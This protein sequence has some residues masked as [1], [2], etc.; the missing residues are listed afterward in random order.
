MHY[1]CAR[2]WLLAAAMAAVLAPAGALA[3]PQSSGRVTL[4]ILPTAPTS[5]HNRH[6]R[7]NRAPLAPSPLVKLPV[8]AVK[9]RGWVLRQLQLEADGMV[10]RLAEISPWLRLEG[11]AWASPTGE[12]A[13]GWEEL[14]YW[15]RGFVDLG[16]VLGDASI[17]KEGRRWVD[18]ILASQRP[19]GYFGP[20]SNRAWPDLWPNMLALY[21]LRSHHE[22]TRDP[23]VIPFMLRYFQWQTSL[24]FERLLADSWQ[25]WRGGD[26]LDILHW[27]YNETGQKWLL[28]QARVNHERTA[29][30]TGG[31]PTWH[32]VNVAQ[33]FREPAQFWQQARDPRYLSATYR[34][35]DTVR[36]QYGEAPGGLFGADEVARPGYTGPRQGAETCTMVE[37][38][39]SHEILTAITGDPLWADRCEEVAFNS[40]P[41]AMTADLRGLHY[42]TAP[43]QVQLDRASKAPMI[44]NGGDMFSYSPFEQYRCC[45]HNVAFGWPYYAEYQWMATPGDGLAAVLYG[46]C[47]VTARVA[48]GTPVTIREETEYP[49]DDTIVFTVQPGAPARFPLTLRI[50]AWCDSPRLEVNGEGYALTRSRDAA[51]DARAALFTPDRG[52]GGWVVVKRAW[53]P[54]DIVRL[55]LPMRV[56]VKEWARNRGAVSVHRGPLTYALRI[57]ERWAP[58]GAN[59]RWPG[60]EV[61]ATMPWNYG[62]EVDPGSAEP[63]VQVV[64]KPAALAAQPFTLAD[65]PIELRVAA[66]R[67]TDWTLE[68]NGLVGEVQPGPV[69]SAEPVE[70][71]TLVPMGCA[72]LR[73]SAFPRVSDGPEAREWG[74]QA[75]ATASQ[76][77]VSDTLAALCD[78]TLP[79]NSADSSVPRFTWYDHL[80][81]AEWVEYTWARPRKL[82][83]SEVYWFDDRPSGGQC[84]APASWKLSWWDGRAWQP[85][86]GASAC[87]VE[88]DGMNRVTFG[89]VETARLRLEAQ[90]QPGF[91]GGILEWRVGP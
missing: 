49:F 42:L 36:A 10:G 18:A 55:T 70:Q 23:R 51:A 90:L 15:L 57:G 78:G 16:G 89:T 82:A 26:S 66:R 65:A 14:P 28:E 67:I 60:F 88:R 8:G 73:I 9:P 75:Q 48:D 3:A 62:L 59:E 53:G 24:P 25:K 11:S 80:G 87:G 81:T 41:A 2:A 50:P 56:R 71:V 76:T 47:E 40:L 86:P 1:V 5:G 38:M 27:L 68:P 33:G 7:G 43:N 39:F 46:P 83:W 22:V 37:M 52:A 64:R 4:R 21:A 58:Y 85:V 17:Q 63:A 77:W 31:I 6:Y 19:D 79:R 32:G 84:R 13:N 30:W 74:A 91:S 69:R 45:Q 44:M 72:R 35:Y 12:G 54:R 29:D 20:E 61:F 34:N